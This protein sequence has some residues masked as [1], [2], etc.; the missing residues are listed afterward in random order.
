MLEVWLK[1]FGKGRSGDF[2]GGIDDREVVIILLNHYQEIV[3]DV[4][5]NWVD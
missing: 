1:K 4:L 3:I 2:Q 5:W